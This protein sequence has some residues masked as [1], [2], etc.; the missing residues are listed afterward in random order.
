MRAIHRLFVAALVIAGLAAQSRAAT[1]TIVNNDGANEGFNDP[2]PVAPVGGN[3]GTTLGQ[4][5]LIVV[6]YAAAIWGSILPSAVEI[7][8]NSQFNPQTCSAA[9]ATLASTSSGSSHRN[10][11]NAPFAQTWYQQSLAN[12]IA[13]VD[14]NPA[15]NDMNC[16][17]NSNLGTSPTCPFSY[18]YGLDGN[19]GTATELLPVALHEMGHGLGFATITTAGVQQGTPP[20]PH[21]YDRFLLD[22]TQGLHWNEMA[23]NAQRGASAINCLNVVW[24]GLCVTGAAPGVLGPKPLA[25][26]LAPAAAAGDYEVGLAA[27][28]PNPFSVTG[29]VVLADDGSAPPNSPSNGCEPLINGAQIAGNIAFIDRGTCP[30]VVKVKNAQDAGAIGVIIA[31][32][33]ASCPPAG[34]AGTD[35]TITIPSVRITLADANQIRP[36]VVAGTVTASLMFDGAIGAGTKA[37]KVLVYTPTT[38]AGGSSVSHWDTSADPSL[39]MEPFNTP[40]V[41]ADVDLTYQHFQDLGWF[42]WPAACGPTAT[43][44]ALFTAE[45]R[46]DGILLRWQFGPGSDAASVAF[47]RGEAESG[48]WEPIDLEVRSDA[49]LSTAL[50]R[51]AEANRTYF[52]QLSVTDQAGNT[53]VLGYVSGR[54]DAALR[55]VFLAAPVPNPSSQG[56]SVQFRL[57]RPEYV[58]LSIVDVNGRAVRSL[59]E[60]MMPAGEHF[61]TWDGR[62]VSPGIYFVSLR[63]SAGIRTQRIVVQ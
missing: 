1:I 41:S 44:L 18:Y 21:V 31:D 56:A 6:Q 47:A 59:H 16:T 2:T 58:R 55:G 17:F 57:E 20:G 28:G 48:P 15:I 36:H 54:R 19:E 23:T 12:R 7:R 35:P 29:N 8:I 61:T 27:F 30:F 32:T 39:I 53:E 26:V 13:G 45:G 43:Q 9:G 63:T 49:G 51:G 52:Y 50:D 22:L 38:F 25:R 4:Q 40:N 37:G 11:A 14:L 60:G 46:D 62:D 24:D 10:F 42:G 5:R 33:V 34:M 3:T